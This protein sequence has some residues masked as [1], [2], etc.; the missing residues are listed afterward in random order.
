MATERSPLV[1]SSSEIKTSLDGSES[2][3]CQPFAHILFQRGPVSTCGINGC[4]I[5]DVIEI[6]QHR[7]E[8]HQQRSL[9]CEENATALQYLGLARDALLTRRGRRIEQG[10]LNTRETHMSKDVE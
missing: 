9:A 3:V 2:I 5:E 7:L 8:D 6:L 1:T 4:R 10:V